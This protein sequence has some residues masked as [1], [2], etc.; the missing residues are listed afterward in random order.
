MLMKKIITL[1]M[2]TLLAVGGVKAQVKK[3]W[4]FSKGWSDKTIENLKADTQNWT[5]EYNSDGSIK[6]IQEKT[7]LTGDFI[8][9]G[10]PIK[11]L[12]GLTRGTAGLS[13]SNNYLLTSSTFRLNRNGQEIIFP[14]LR[15]G[16]TITIVGKSANATAEDRGIKPAYDYIV[17][18]EGPED[19][20][21][22]A[23]LGVV[24][25]KWRV[26]GSEDQEYDIKFTMITGGIDFT[27]FMIDDGDEIPTTQVAFLSKGD[28]ETD[29]AYQALKARENTMVTV[30]DVANSSITV[31]ALRAYDVTV[32]SKTLSADDAAVAVVKEAMPWTPVLNLNAD[33]YAV[34]GYGE[35]AAG[36]PFAALKN[37][38]NNLFAGFVQDEDYI[39][40]DELIG[41]TFEAS[42]LTGVKLA[43]YFADDEILAT[44]ATGDIVYIHAHNPNHNGYVY[45][46]QEAVVSAKL[47]ENAIN[48]L[49]ES[50]ET[51][52]EQAPA[53]EIKQEFKD[54]NTNVIVTSVRQL[55]KVRIFYTIDGSEPTMESTEYTDTV[56]LTTPCVF[57]AVE[58]AEGYTLSNSASLDIKIVSQPKIP[59]ISDV[60]ENGK[61]T[62]SLSC[63]TADADIW[64]NFTNTTDTLLSTK[65]VEPF[66]IQMP[67]NITVFSVADGAVWSEAL[68]KRVLVN[69]PRVVIDIVGHFAANQW[70]G[71][72][73]GSGLFAGGKNATSMY[74]KTKDPVSSGTDPD[75]GDP[76]VVYPEVEYQIKDES[77]EE[78]LWQVMTKGQAVLWQNN[79]A[80]TE[81]VGTDEGGYYPYSATDISTMFAVTANDIQF[82]KIFA[83]EHANAAIQSKVKYKAPLDVVLIANMEGGPLLVQVSADGENWI[84]IGE[85]AK[86]GKKR[87]WKMY[88]NSYDGTDEVYVRVA[89]ETG[90]AA[91]KIFDIYVANQGEESLKLL[92]EL[93]QEYA[94]GIQTVTDQKAKVMEG[95]YNIN[96]MRQQSL[97]RGLN[98]V[99]MG[100]G[101]VR[102]VMVK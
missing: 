45:L 67:Q 74:D 38:K 9:N 85:I 6:T 3:T 80:S 46:P 89:Q 18:T 36:E 28:I 49:V 43:A 44:N 17:R 34:W 75:T 2:L 5:I 78:P 7:K 94:T 8:A 37:L 53:P 82:S 11:E 100:D 91:S 61:T 20:L 33:L 65:Y 81:K 70:D 41:M 10:Q 57:K 87:M 95:I 63:E 32:L 84:N 59:V 73:N 66:T 1:T 27:L 56:N 19:N 31:D 68:S 98:I 101:T 12:T 48:L 86:T 24:T 55:P 21:I 79:K 71:I 96:G 97:R 93:N 88:T 13:K 22:R 83:G 102:K 99:V 64:Y 50:K 23:S 51:E 15:G 40:V 62:V 25:N 14:R 54:L 42:Q 39:E 29:I 72:G 16:Q 76:I 90:A 77:A 92:N 26:D 4:D 69:N 30:I 58:I 60:Q 35:A 52:I 47:L